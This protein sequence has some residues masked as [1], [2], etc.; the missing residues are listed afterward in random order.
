[1]GSGGG[2]G[3]PNLDLQQNG[4]PSHT[5]SSITSKRVVT[6]SGAT[7]AGPILLKVG[8]RVK[9]GQ[10]PTLVLKKHPSTATTPPI[11]V[12]TLPPTDA[13]IADLKS[14]FGCDT[15]EQ[16]F[17]FTFT[18]LPGLGRK[19]DSALTLAPFEPTFVT[20]G[21]FQVLTTVLCHASTTFSVGPY[22]YAIS[23][24]PGSNTAGFPLSAL[25]SATA[26]KKSKKKYA[27][28]PKTKVKKKARR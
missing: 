10:T 6:F 27:K 15:E 3:V 23:A 28:K 5:G 14:T 26:K 16:W 12:T 11:L 25:Q 20:S 8:I 13:V 4:I 24:L 2:G 21:G 1:M 18:W 22:S 7:T 9:A 19:F 17:A